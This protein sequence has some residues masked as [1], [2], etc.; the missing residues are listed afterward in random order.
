M[1]AA[2]QAS[3]GS[4]IPL[5]TEPPKIRL[6]YV[7][8]EPAL[9]E[10]TKEF[11]EMSGEFEVDT[12]SSAEQALVALDA[13]VHRAVISDYK[14]PGM[15][16]I[17]FLRVLRGRGNDIPFILFTG[18]GREEIAI[19]AINNG[20]DFY[21]KKGGDP[22]AQFAELAN[23]IRQAVARRETEDA[24]VYNLR[25][26][27]A[28][29]EN[30]TDIIVEI[31]GEGKVKYASP[32]VSSIL[33]YEPDEIIGTLFLR[34]VNP[35]EA[36]E[37]VRWFSGVLQTQ[38]GTS[39]EILVRTKDNDWCV[40][41]AGAK[42]RSDGPPSIV[43]NARDVT[44]RRGM[45]H[46]LK[47]L[48][49]TLA[50][51]SDVNQAIVRATDTDRLFKRLCRIA[52]EKGNFGMAWVGLADPETRM[53]HP[54]ASYGAVEGY[55]DG[56]RVSIDDE[57][58]G[59]GPIGGAI[60]TNQIVVVDDIATDPRM[61]PWREK[62]LRNG[63]LGTVGVPIRMHGEPIAALGIYSSEVGR[64]DEEEI[65]LLDEMAED[66]SLAISSIDNENKHHVMEVRLRESE[67]RFR[68]VFK[69]AATG[70]C[71]L[72]TDGRFIDVNRSFCAM[73][74][75]SEDE[76]KRI[77][78]LDVTHPDDV[79]KSRVWV[80]RMLAGKEAPP[81]IEKRYVRKDGRTVWGDVSTTLLR[82]R[83]GVALYFI[84]EIND[85][86]ESRETS[87]MLK[88][89]ET[90][91]RRL[92]E[93]AKDGILIL[94]EGTGNIIDANSFI[95][96]MTGYSF[97]D[98]A[99][100]QLWELG[101]I[102]D[103]SK[104]EEAFR[105]LKR[106]GYVRYEDL[107]LRSASGKILDVEFVSNVYLVD[108]RKIIQCNIRD[109]SERKRALK[110]RDELEKSL[111]LSRR[112]LSLM[113]DLTRHDIVNQLTV[114]FGYLEIIKT[115]TS[116]PALLESA[117]KLKLAMGN[118]QKLIAFT[119]MYQDLGLSAPEWQSVKTVAEFAASQVTLGSIEL[120]IKCEDL[121]IL[122]DR[123]LEKVFFNLLENSVK[124]GDRVTRIR[125][126]C[127]DVSDA[128]RIAIEDD[129]IGIPDTDKERIFEKGFGR[130]TGL[131]LF[132][133]REV[134]AT[135]NISIVENGAP[136]KGARFELTVPPGGWRTKTRR[137]T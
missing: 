81:H 42:R 10:I 30:A 105:A 79:E 4:S 7:D 96:E 128:L 22:E 125:V 107:P 118:I 114:S 3:Q 21:L 115:K 16:G 72:G 15:D 12:F 60:R 58:E 44:E 67:E 89:S 122:A 26:F 65:G 102:H 123:M 54:V 126:A 52:V 43:I 63:F 101:L 24:M 11:M 116:D 39:R 109:I 94:D 68:T 120:S 14:M 127:G 62:A 34:Y 53:V 136:G 111:E 2:I 76:L 38:A 18:K 95:L 110:E 19:E 31:D 106:I 9:L 47:S 33:G 82:D 104:A 36:D 5:E 113:T 129:G 86:T 1:R 112:K 45:L 17:E 49:R 87:E 99:N 84:T 35:A 23:M 59:S 28:L 61:E 71:I 132:L 88:E 92:F 32:S 66:I 56:I 6:Q 80:E 48:N 27:R 29:I 119:K 131:G 25:H 85:I 41:E 75:Y 135:T 137:S 57:P 37:L 103:R 100:R 50:L 8:D 74:G 46:R 20:A 108:S 69:G 117:G 130:N 13:E 91:Y 121:E 133:T 90:R 134:L 70:M 40:L 124:H 77:G 73:L 51:I 83:N 97:G 78:F 98:L 64:F 93:T 55:L